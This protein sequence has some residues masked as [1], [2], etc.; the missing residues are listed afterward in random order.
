MKNKGRFEV[1]KKNGKYVIV[2][3][4]K[5]EQLD[6]SQF[7]TIYSFVNYELA[8]QYVEDNKSSLDDFITNYKEEKQREIERKLAEEKARE[9]EERRNREEQERIKE[10]KRAKRR[11][12]FS[13][14]KSFVAGGLVFSMLL[15]GGHFLGVGISKLNKKNR[16]NNNSQSS[17]DNQEST[18]EEPKYAYN[19]D[20]N[21]VVIN[22][23]EYKELTT[24]EFENIT[25]IKVKELSDKGLNLNSEDV[26]KFMMI[27]NCDKLAQD[28]KELITQIMGEQTSD[29]VQ[30]DAYKCVGAIVVYN[31][32]KW[33]QEGNDKNFIKVSD[34][35]FDEEARNKVIEI[36]KRVSEIALSVND[37]DKFNQLVNDFLKDL[38]DPTN[39][40]SYLES[41]VGF[42][43]QIVLEPIRGLYGMDLYGNITLDETNAE[44]IKYFVPYAGDEEEYKENNMLT[45]Y[46]KDINDILTDCP[47]YTRKLT[48]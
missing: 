45:G 2:Y 46:I 35:V 4:E 40:L 17:L 20:K 16:N 8:S 43:L 19:Y 5:G 14:W 41:G 39:E 34:C 18:K 9:E 6:L 22:D 30:Q 29:E 38:L 3:I 24:E 28:N 23:E 11:K 15:T 25:S 36:E 32:N 42:V 12:F 13:G 37:K 47:A 26:I 1:L 44:L 48:D 7:N 10:E 21:V 33:Y 27:V 31:Y